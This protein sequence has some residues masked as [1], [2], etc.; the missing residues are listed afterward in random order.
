MYMTQRYLIRY[1]NPKWAT[2]DKF[3][4]QV[5]RIKFYNLDSDIELV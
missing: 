4:K 1:P 2:D 3:V 5:G